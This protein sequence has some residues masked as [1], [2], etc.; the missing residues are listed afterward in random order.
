MHQS[1]KA[2]GQF[3]KVIGPPFLPRRQL[4][5]L[6]KDINLPSRA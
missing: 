5:I 6:D 1:G 2:A 4:E 3:G